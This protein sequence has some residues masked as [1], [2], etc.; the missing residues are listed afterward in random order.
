MN[1]ILAAL[2][3]SAAAVGAAQAGETGYLD[4][5]ATQQTSARADQSS[6]ANRNQVA[7]S[8]Y[9]NRAQGNQNASGKPANPAG[10]TFVNG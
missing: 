7:A 5:P 9:D 8:Q 4:N 6:T 2:F 3:I 10:A 1:R